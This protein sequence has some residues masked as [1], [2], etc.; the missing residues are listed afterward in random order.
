MTADL[1]PIRNEADY[2]AALEEVGRLWGAKSGTP[3][4][5]KLDVLATLID[6]YEAKH[7]PIDPPDPVEAIR[8]RMEQQG[9]TRKDLEPMIGPRNRVA[10]VLNRK[11]G[12]SIDMIRQLHDGL[13]ISAE[14]LIRPSRMDKVA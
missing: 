7:H 13:G 12:L 8:F 3:D 2:D 1:K 4:G 6:A 9:L 11:R 5:D 14:V 10:D